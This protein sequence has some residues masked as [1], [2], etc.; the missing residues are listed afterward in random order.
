MSGG[1]AKALF[2]EDEYE[3]RVTQLAENIKPEHIKRS[4]NKLLLRLKGQTGMGSIMYKKNI[5]NMLLQDAEYI[6]DECLRYNFEEALYKYHDALPMH[7]TVTLTEK[8]ISVMKRIYSNA[9]AG[10]DTVPEMFYN[11]NSFFWIFEEW[12]PK[13]D[14]I[15]FKN[16]FFKIVKY[17]VERMIKSLKSTDLEDVKQVLDFVIQDFRCFLK[18]D[19][20]EDV[21]GVLNMVLTRARELRPRL[22]DLIN[23]LKTVR[24]EAENNLQLPDHIKRKIKGM[25]KLRL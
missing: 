3:A 21:I 5:L 1:E 19:L 17:C 16:V 20:P 11:G 10:R 24:E 8:L 2:G 14:M 18:R 7:P 9:G 25:A 15:E 13:H 23:E 4:V 12:K 22:L 6:E